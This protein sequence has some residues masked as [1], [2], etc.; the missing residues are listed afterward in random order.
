MYLKAFEGSRN[1]LNVLSLLH[2]AAGSD[3]SSAEPDL[4]TEAPSTSD[5]DPSAAGGPQQEAPSAAQGNY[6]VFSA[7]VIQMELADTVC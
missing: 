4:A 2:A 6:A 7:V 3:P 5:Q 1:A